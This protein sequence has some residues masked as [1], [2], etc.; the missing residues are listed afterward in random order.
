VTAQ[1]APPVLTD[2]RCDGR[3]RNGALCGKLIARVALAPGSMVELVCP[4]CRSRITARA[5]SR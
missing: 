3:A 5:Q 2:V 1:T 4:K